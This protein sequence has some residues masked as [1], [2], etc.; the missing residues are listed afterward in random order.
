MRAI[1]KKLGMRYGKI[2]QRQFYIETKTTLLRCYTLLDLSGLTCKENKQ[3]FSGLHQ[4]GSFRATKEY[5]KLI[6]SSPFV[7]PQIKT[8]KP[9]NPIRLITSG[10][11][12]PKVKAT[13]VWSD[14]RDADFSQPISIQCSHSIAP[15]AICVPCHYQRL[16][17]PCHHQGTDSV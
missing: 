8:H 17:A 12:A 11:T 7:F 16:C 1:M 2:K 10:K 15:A 14:A 6:F 5:K 13:V 3:S 4:Q 9:N